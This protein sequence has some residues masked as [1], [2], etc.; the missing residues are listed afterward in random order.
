MSGN[1]LAQMSAESPSNISPNPSEVISEVLEP[2][3]GPKP[4]VH[5]DWETTVNNSAGAD[6]GLQSR[7]QT[8]PT[9]P[10]KSYPKFGTLGQLLKIPPLSP[11][12]LHS[13]GGRR[14]PRVFFVTLR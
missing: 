3:I 11:Q 1:F 14:G 7:L 12:N 10:H 6:G 13:V 4:M 5:V 8:S 2:T 9:A